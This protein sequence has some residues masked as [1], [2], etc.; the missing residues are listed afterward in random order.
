MQE[1]LPPLDQGKGLELRLYFGVFLSVGG[2]GIS[3]E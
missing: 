3:S 2:S 1:A